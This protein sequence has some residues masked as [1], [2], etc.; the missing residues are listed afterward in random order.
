MGIRYGQHFL[1]DQSVVSEIIGRFNPSGPII[2]VGPGRGALT[3]FLLKRPNP[4]MVIEI[5]SVLQD[6]WQKRA[7]KLPQLHVMER[8]VLSFD[9]NEWN[10]WHP[11]PF[12]IISNLPYEISGPFLIRLAKHTHLWTECLL[13]LQ[14]E[15]VR[16]VL[17]EPGHHEYGRLSVQMQR[18]CYLEA[19]DVIPPTAFS[20]PPRVQSQLLALK[21]RKDTYDVSCEIVWDEMLRLAFCH[22][23][24]MIRRTFKAFNVDWEFIGLD[25]ALRPEN[26]SVTDWV[27]LSNYLKV[28]GMMDSLSL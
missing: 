17:A 22:R 18:H 21:P 3:H 7:L 4:L 8:D 13:M 27:K 16:K 19:L 20:P 26:L 9:W 5:D 28:L 24:Q 23:R 1:T 2:E 12:A 25:G 14:L 11:G 6:Y 10:A 15:I